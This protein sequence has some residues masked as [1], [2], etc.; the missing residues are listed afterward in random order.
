MSR[1]L[2]VR[3]AAG[4]VRERRDANRILYSLA[5]D[6]LALCV[7]GFLFSVC[8]EQMVLRHR[9]TFPAEEPSRCRRCGQTMERRILVS[10]RVDPG[11]LAA[12]LP[13]P[14]GRRWSTGTAWRASA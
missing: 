8:P 7:G 1:H 11:V 6:R 5:E 13:P 2:S 12:W 9:R 3:K 4:R 10:Y 14:S